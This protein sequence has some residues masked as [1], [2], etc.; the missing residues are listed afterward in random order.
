VSAPGAPPEL[1]RCLD[2]V[3]HDSTGECRWNEVDW[4]DAA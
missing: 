2:T 1:R 4:V 3:R